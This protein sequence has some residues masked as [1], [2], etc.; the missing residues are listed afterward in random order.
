M[1]PFEYASATSKEQVA[2]LLGE[3]SAILAG[4]SDLSR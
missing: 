4:G 3:T 2:A 1:H